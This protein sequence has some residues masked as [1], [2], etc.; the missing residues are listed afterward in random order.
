MHLDLTNSC[1]TNCVTCWDHSPWLTEAR[2]AAWKR[3]RVERAAVSALLDDIESLG[4]LRALILSGMGDPL[5]HPQAL[6][7]VA[8]AKRRGLHVT[9]ITN[10]VAAAP[11]AVLASG[12]DQLLIGIHGASEAS[13]LAFHP[14]FRPAEWARLREGL[15]AFRAAG[16]RFKHVHVIC[17]T[18][19]HELPD[20][21]ELAAEFPAEIVNFKL[22]SLHSG[23]ERARLRPEQREAL[24]E[25]GI[26]TARELAGALG[27]ATNLDVFEG[28]LAAGGD[29]TAD[30]AS[31][32]CFMGTAYSRVLVDGTVLYCCNVDVVVGRLSE[33]PFSAL[34]RG[35]EWA[36]LRAR[37][38]EGRYLPSCRQCGKIN[39]NVKLSNT[40]RKRFGEARWR[41][42]VGLSGAE[43]PP[44]PA[45]RSTAPAGGPP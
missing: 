42:V 5:T 27:V 15:A 19:A 16:R 45:D 30:I 37:F 38:R 25:E 31:I 39:Q 21:V 33:Q 11:E 7:M 8:D 40:F 36:A 41:A 34:W 10:L 4:G 32:G 18:N 3:Q 6:D 2:S 1:N 20:M 26:P 22:A 14:S 43:V 13:Y 23:T 12:V 24:L 9:I 29:D 17:E 35:P 44:P 28:Q